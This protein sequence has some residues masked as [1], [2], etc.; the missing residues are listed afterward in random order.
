ML[1]VADGYS[2]VNLVHII[3]TEQQVGDSPQV[4]GE[5]WKAGR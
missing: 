1:T 2:S 5:E 3:L 4:P